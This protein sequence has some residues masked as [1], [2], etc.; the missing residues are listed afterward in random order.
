M[1]RLL[2]QTMACATGPAQ[3]CENGAKKMEFIFPPGFLAFDGH[4]PERPILPGIVQIMAGIFVAGGG[5]PLTLGKVVRAK[6]TRIINPG[7]P[8]Q[9]T[10]ECGDNGGV[11]RANIQVSVNGETAASISLHLVPDGVGA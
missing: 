3:T 9:I 2:Q 10:A 11:I 5:R 8:V 7:E 4:F 6:F 1:N